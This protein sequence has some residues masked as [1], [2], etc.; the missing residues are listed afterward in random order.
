MKILRTILQVLGILFLAA[1]VVAVGMYFYAF[2]A[3]AERINQAT[4]NQTKFVLN[5]GGINANQNYSVVFS[6]ESQNGFLP[7]HLIYYCLQLKEFSVDE[8]H[9]EEWKAGPE[10]NPVFSQAI[11]T[12]V[13]SVNDKECFT[14]HGKINSNEIQTFFWSVH[15]NGRFPSGAKVLL[16]EPSSS[17]L[18][19]VDYET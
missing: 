13:N 9:R 12:A 18:L 6:Y 19:Y 15:T 17:R 14:H 1:I 8:N 11:E 10:T 3:P 16:Y 4:E 5:W 7:D 2:H